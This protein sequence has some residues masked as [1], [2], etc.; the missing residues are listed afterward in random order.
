MRLLRSRGFWLTMLVV[1]SFAAALW[2]SSDYFTHWLS[3]ADLLRGWIASFGPMAPLAYIS[4]YILQI[5]VAPVPGNFMGM[6]AGYMFGAFWGAVYGFCALAIGVSLVVTFSR[7]LGRPMVERFFSASQLKEWESKLRVRSP[8]T[9]CIIFMFPVPDLL[10]YM[11]GLSSVKL[12]ILLPAI[13]IGR[14]ISVVFANIVGHW[15]A[16]LPPETVMLLWAISAAVSLLIYQ[17]RRRL[18]IQMLLFARRLKQQ[19]RRLRLQR[20]YVNTPL[21]E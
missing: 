11:A 7:L 3:Q 18:R 17:H 6:L 4:V 13:I 20:R 15:S 9:W 10:I 1:S 5:I 19:R 12:R 14:T 8:L 21:P 2:A 16:I